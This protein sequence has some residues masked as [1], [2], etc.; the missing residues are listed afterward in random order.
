MSPYHFVANLIHR[1]SILSPFY[2]ATATIADRANQSLERSLARLSYLKAAT[3]TE[4]PANVRGLVLAGTGITTA[5]NVL[6]GCGREINEPNREINGI[7][8]LGCGEESLAKQLGTKFSYCIGNIEDRNYMHNRLIIGNGAVLVGGWTPLVIRNDLYYL[9]FESIKVGHRTLAINPRV[10]QRTPQGHRGLIIDSGTENTYL[11][12]DA[13]LALRDTVEEII[14]GELMRSFDP[15]RPTTLLLWKGEPKPY[16][17]SY[18]GVPFS[19]R[20]LFEVEQRK[21]L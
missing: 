17:I 21:P 6:F 16:N 15:Q 2:N 12:R 8:G 4:T 19:W 10:F 18:S 11:I 14:G 3:K 20:S 13:Y 5:R 9:R 7:M 1:D